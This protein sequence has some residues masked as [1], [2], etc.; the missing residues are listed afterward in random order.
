MTAK[1]SYLNSVSRARKA[2]TME[3]RVLEHT[4][5]NRADWEK[6]YASALAHG[7]S[8]ERAESCTIDRYLCK[9]DCPFYDLDLA[10]HKKKRKRV[11]GVKRTG[12]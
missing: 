1:A 4:A 2:M 9:T 3:Q 12:A 11:V 8:L 7:Y 6:C 10:T 5:P